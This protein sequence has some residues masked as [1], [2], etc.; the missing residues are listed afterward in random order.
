MTRSAIAR[1][2]LSPIT[3]PVGLFGKLIIRA[4]D[5]AVIFSASASGFSLK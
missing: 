1:K 2:S 4:F 3:P 5:L